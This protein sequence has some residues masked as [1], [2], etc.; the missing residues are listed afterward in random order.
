MAD[1]VQEVKEKTDIV[2]VI[3]EHVELKRSGRNFKGLCPFHGEKT[4]S[5][6]VS[7][8][9]QIYKCFGCGRGGDVFTFLEEHEGMDFPE[10]LK[11]LA[12]RAGIKLVY[13]GAHVNTENQQIIE[14]ND[15]AARLYHYILIKHDL[16]KHALEYVRKTRK[17][18]NET[19]V[20]FQIGYAPELTNTL[21]KQ[22]KKHGI[23]TKLAEHA[24]LIYTGRGGETDRFR[25]RVIFPI[26]DS[27]GNTVALGGR[28]L[29]EISD[30]GYA[31]YIN[32]P[33]T[34][35]YHKSE[36][37]FGLHLAKGEIRREKT[38][39]IVEGEM[40]MIS[41]FQAGI[42]NVVAIKGTALTPEHVK[43]LSRYT[44]TLVLA[45]DSDFAGDNAAVRSIRLAQDE[46]MI[47]KV[48][49]MGS[50]KDP[51][52]FAQN[53]PE[54]YKAAL[55]DADD[56]WQFLIDVS[57]AKHDA[58]TG[59]GKAALSREVIPVLAN[60]QDR[61]VQAHYMQIVSSRLGVS[62]EDVMAQLKNS[63]ADDKRTHPRNV[64]PEV[65][66][67]QARSRR[68]LLE[69][70]MIAMAI[71]S[72]PEFLPLDIDGQIQEKALVRIL[73][74]LRGGGRNYDM[75]SFV[76]ALPDELKEI[77]AKL[78]LI[79]LDEEA[80]SEEDLLAVVREYRKYVVRNH[81]NG[82][83][84]QISKAQSER[85]H[86]K[87]KELEREITRTTEELSLLEGKN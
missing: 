44:D 58:E 39:I 67:N 77:A 73:A 16:G 80:P 28:I 7:Q 20:T 15:F 25:G 83:A 56:I 40:D 10:A 5:F 18:T 82:L 69:E 26:Y 65:S 85:D 59:M 36:I 68:D 71:Q 35:V 42:K 51:D 72:S 57:F 21:V 31:K 54:G 64:T 61:I 22:L 45:L 30:K 38:A 52:E 3:G 6:M 43:I 75:A 84:Q 24:G 11:F 46:G 74:A 41:S 33:E 47:I 81:L 2:Q 79:E 8:A 49:R 12:G 78:S 48:A 55:A 29:P 1:Q 4:P 34:P 62:I 87:V 66:G 76:A 70:Q 32:S 60:I 63:D 9:L 50:F 27:R 14:L 86:K 37:L 13:E 23:S 19:I 53:D 17:L